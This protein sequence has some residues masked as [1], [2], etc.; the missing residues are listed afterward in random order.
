MDTKAAFGFAFVLVALGGLIALATGRLSFANGQITI[1]DPRKASTSTPT[2]ITAPVAGATA[3]AIPSTGNGGWGTVDP[4]APVLSGGNLNNA[5]ISQI[6]GGNGSTTTLGQ[7]YDPSQT[8]AL[9]NA[10]AGD[11][12]AVNPYGIGSYA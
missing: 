1:G 3:T 11:G 5:A 7:I 12:A 6:I 2:P 8:L 4:G 9:V 10:I